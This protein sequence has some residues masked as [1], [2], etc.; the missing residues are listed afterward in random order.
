MRGHR[1]AVAQ[2]RIDRPVAYIQVL[3]LFRFVFLVRHVR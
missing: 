2:R 3:N 1:L